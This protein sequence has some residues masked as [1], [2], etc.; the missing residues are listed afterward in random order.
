MSDE[1]ALA[2]AKYDLFGQRFKAT[3]Y[4]TY[5][6]MR[7][8]TPVYR[9]AN[10]SGQGATC[11]V[12][13]YDEAVMVLRDHRHF[14]KDIRNTLTPDEQAAL[15]PLPPLL[16]LLSHHMLN[17]D[18]PDHTRLRGLVNQAF[19]VRIV[20]QLQ[21]RVETIAHTLL[22]R[23]QPRGQADLIESFA[24]PLPIIVIAELLGIPAKD[25]NRFR[26]WSN[27]LVVP[28]ADETRTSKKLAK[29]RQLM[30]DFISYLREVFA[31]RRR[32]PRD[33]L[34]TSLLAAEEAGDALSE[35]ELFSMILLLVVVGHETT[36]NLIGN[37]A[38]AL[39]THPDQLARLQ[40]DR[41]LLPSAVEELLRFDCPVERA[42]MRFAA[43]DVALGG[44]LIRRGDAVS[45]VL[46]SANR[47]S[48][49]FPAAEH[50]ELDR[51]PNRHLA[52][53]LGVH[54]CLGAALARLEGEVALA[55]LLDRLPGLALAALPDQ[56]RWRTHPIMRGVQ[57]L[58]VR[59]T[60]GV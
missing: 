6:Q 7:G 22:D 35:E 37:G 17:L 29:S 46:G 15:P 40:A 60:P 47:D 34:I 30:Q 31:A 24:F 26:A 44:A 28:T 14:V 43:E 25:R 8:H 4:D 20:E 10:A 32:Q 57:Q 58:P 9:R 3:A 56:L 19:T 12:T 1:Q 16:R 59:W 18:A 55:A 36:V 13:T 51:E 27:A 50:L 53:G 5:A 33:D 54:Y 42:P 11:F 38:L 49:I 41:A 39:L 48:L 2:P 52:F 23:V 45:V 21:P